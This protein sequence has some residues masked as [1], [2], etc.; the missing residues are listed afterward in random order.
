MC[1]PGKP[2]LTEVTA[3]A[4]PLKPEPAGIGPRGEVGGAWEVSSSP[5]PPSHLLSPHLPVPLLL[6]P[7]ATL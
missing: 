1:A 2:V 5:P 3:S 6:R 4:K 7:S